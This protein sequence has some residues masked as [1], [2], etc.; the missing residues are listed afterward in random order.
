MWEL[1]AMRTAINALEP[2]T[3]PLVVL[4]VKMSATICWP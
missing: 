4:L 1:P 2:A 3:S